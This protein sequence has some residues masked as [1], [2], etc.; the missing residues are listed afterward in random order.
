[1][2]QIIRTGTG[3]NTTFGFSSPTVAVLLIETLVYPD[4]TNTDSAEQFQ[5]TVANN[6]QTS[7]SFNVQKAFK[8][9]PFAEYD[10]SKVKFVLTCTEY[11]NDNGTL[12][13]I[14]SLTINDSTN[15]L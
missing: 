9:I 1:M 11:I 8:N 14:S 5:L 12:Q 4:K 13:P 7:V 10:S 3:T 15:I 2:I 6:N